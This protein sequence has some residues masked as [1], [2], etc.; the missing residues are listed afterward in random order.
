MITIAEM[1]LS[2][3][4]V[5]LR[6]V[7]VPGSTIFPAGTPLQLVTHRKH[8]EVV[9]AVWKT[10]MLCPLAQPNHEIGVES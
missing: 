2:Y 3:A 7:I 5:C 6:D 8:V 9:A 10:K 4:I 1:E